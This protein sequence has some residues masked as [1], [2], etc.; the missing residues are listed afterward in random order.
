MQILEK[1]DPELWEIARENMERV[2]LILETIEPYSDERRKVQAFRE[3]LAELESG[4]TAPRTAGNHFE[5]EEVHVPRSDGDGSIR[6]AIF[7]PEGKSDTLP[8]L[9]FIHGGGMIVGSI[10]NIREEATKLANLLKV[11]VVAVEYR[12]APEH[13]HPAPVNDCFDG[14]NWVARNA[15]KLGIDPSRIGMFG[16]S[17]GGGLAAATALMIRDRGGSG[18][19]FQVLIAPMLDDRNDTPSSRQFSG[20]WPGWPREMNLLGW[21]ALL[22]N[23]AGTDRVSEYAAPSRA[24]DLS[25]LPETYIEVAGLELFRDED[26]S[27]G[28]RLMEHNVP[29]EMHVYPGTFHSWHGL[30]PEAAVTKR[31]VRNRMEWIRRQYE[32][33]KA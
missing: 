18:L 28:Q 26:I 7:R 32:S 6:L 21:Q 11:V 23:S 25:D 31:A 13:P 24:S 12:L 3:I 15:A 14:F 17:A 2:R 20:V 19:L 1:F 9:Y 8:C 22:G 33:R 5:T 16:E 29:V 10:D 4:N 30:A 27:Y